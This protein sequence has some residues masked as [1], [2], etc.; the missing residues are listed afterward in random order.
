MWQIWTRPLPGSPQEPHLGIWETLVLALKQP[1]RYHEILS[2]NEAQIYV[3]G[4]AFLL[5]V[6]CDFFFDAQR[7]LHWLGIIENNGLVRFLKRIRETV[8]G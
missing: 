3:F 8:D 6:F 7:E 5:M 2:E 1:Q 4:G